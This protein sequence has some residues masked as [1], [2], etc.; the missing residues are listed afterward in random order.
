[1][2]IKITDSFEEAVCK[3][4]EGNPGAVRCIVDMLETSPERGMAAMFLCDHYELYGS[5]LY[6]LWN[7]LCAR[8]SE[9]LINIIESLES[10]AIKEIMNGEE[11]KQTPDNVEDIMEEIERI[12]TKMSEFAHMESKPLEE[13]MTGLN[14]SNLTKKQALEILNVMQKIETT[15]N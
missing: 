14:E 8:D 15:M 2:K 13:L 3:I 7:D 11:N 12:A 1:M 10:D 9:M 5:K 6:E 4:A